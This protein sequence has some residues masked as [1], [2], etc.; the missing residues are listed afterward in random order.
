LSSVV[1]GKVLPCYIF[2]EGLV[3]TAKLGASDYK[4]NNKTRKPS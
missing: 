1:I 4:L 3:N 2:T